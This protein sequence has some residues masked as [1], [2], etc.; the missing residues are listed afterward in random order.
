MHVDFRAARA[1]AVAADRRT[2]IRVIAPDQARP[3][4]ASGD[5]AGRRAG[6]AAEQRRPWRGQ[7]GGPR[8]RRWLDRGKHRSGLAR[9]AQRAQ[10]HNRRPMAIVSLGDRRVQVKMLVRVDVIERAGRSREGL[11][12][13][14]D[15]GRELSRGRAA[16]TK[17]SSPSARHV[18]ARNGR[19]R[20]TR[21]GIARGGSTGLPSTSDQMQPDAQARQSRARARRRPRPPGAPTIRLAAV[22]MPSPMRLLDR[23]VD[24]AAQARNRRP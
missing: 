20:P 15:L 3:K 9:H 12:L 18:V 21:S 4:T 13:R 19:R 5:V 11:E 7:H 2:A 6:R 24:L 14:L 8:S 10:R 1:E 23:L 17:M 22:R 16:A